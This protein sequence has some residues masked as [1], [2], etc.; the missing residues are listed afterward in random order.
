MDYKF[1]FLLGSSLEHFAEKDYS[2]Y[3]TEQRFFQTLDTIQSVR[4]KVP[5]AYICLFECS[6][7]PISNEHKD[8]LKERVDLFLEFYDDPG[9]QVLYENL[10]KNPALFTFG[11][12]LLETRGL[13]CVLEYLK[14][15]QVFTDVQRIFKLTGR[16]SLNDDFN[17]QDYESRLLENQYVAKTFEYPEIENDLMDDVQYKNFY[18][19]IYKSKGSMVTGLWSFDRSLF[20]ETVE[21]LEKSFKYMEKMITCTS[22]IDIEHSLYY[23]LDKK[24]ILRSSNL[25]LNVI[26]GMEESTYQI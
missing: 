10:N 26:K 17:I 5:N 13:L 18:A 21:A 23:Y 7:K 6:C 9:L 19:F 2:R 8:I 25:G 14:Q 24:K 3:T 11:K 15:N 20:V 4:D 1:L 16:Y 12:S 22:G